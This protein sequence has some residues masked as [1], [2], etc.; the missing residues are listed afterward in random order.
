MGAIGTA[1]GVGIVVGQTAV[2]AFV[3]ATE[4]ALSCILLKEAE[5]AGHL[6][7]ERRDA[8]LGRLAQTPETSGLQ[9]DLAGAL[10]TG[11]PNPFGR[12]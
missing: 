9:R 7:P 4:I 3:P 10:R 1:L 5:S 6:P 11:C 12:K 2:R 8:L